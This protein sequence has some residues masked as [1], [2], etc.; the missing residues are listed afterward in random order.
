MDLTNPQTESVLISVG[1]I[2]AGVFISYGA[3][4]TGPFAPT[5]LSIGIETIASGIDGEQYAIEAGQGATVGQTEK[6]IRSGEGNGLFNTL[7]HEISE[8]D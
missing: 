5:V 1:V 8:W 3:I 4:Y 7:L 6:V 2:A